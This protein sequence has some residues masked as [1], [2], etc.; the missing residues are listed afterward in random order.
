[1]HEGRQTLIFDIQFALSRQLKA[2]RRAKGIEDCRIPAEAVL[3]HLELCG[4]ELTRKPPRKSLGTLLG[5][6]AES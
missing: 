6:G 3:K 2:L 5:G 4:L 1:M